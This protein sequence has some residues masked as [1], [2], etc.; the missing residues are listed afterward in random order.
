MTGRTRWSSRIGVGLLA[1][2]VMAGAA[3]A[4]ITWGAQTAIPGNYAWN[5]SNSL[6]FT[7]TPGGSDFRLHEAFVSDNALPEAIY[8]THS[9]NGTSWSAQK[10]GVRQ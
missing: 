10:E 9:G 4:A 5:Y 7:G 8:Y 1:T 6:D 3:L 2:V